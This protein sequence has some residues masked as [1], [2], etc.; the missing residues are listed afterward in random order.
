MKSKKILR[1]LLILVLAAVLIVGVFI[2]A[3]PEE[4]QAAMPDEAARQPTETVQP[5][6]APVISA[7]AA[8]AA[9]GDGEPYVLLDVRTEAEFLAG[10]ISDALLIPYVEVAAWAPTALLD[11][12]I[13]IF[14]YCQS[15]RR[16]AEAA[17]A[18]LRLGFTNVYDFGGIADWP[19]ETVSG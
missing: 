13:R 11:R 17:S 1:P 16:S 8:R 18:L 19:Y 3:R 10:H 7:S 12:D 5:L 15:G 14:V 4:E 2:L 6:L 9:M